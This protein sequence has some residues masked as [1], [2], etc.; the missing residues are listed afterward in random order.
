[1]QYDKEFEE[2]WK[3]ST[4][5][6]AEMKKEYAWEVWQASRRDMYRIGEEVQIDCTTGGYG[7]ERGLVGALTAKLGSGFVDKP[8][9]VR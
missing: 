8:L 6:H 7:W 5:W 4:N 3:Y 2:Y 1:M 9:R